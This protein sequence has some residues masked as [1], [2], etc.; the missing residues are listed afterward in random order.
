VLQADN[1]NWR[2]ICALEFFNAQRSTLKKIVILAASPSILILK[3]LNQGRTAR[4]SPWFC[5]FKGKLE[6]SEWNVL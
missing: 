3:K 2:D 5:T 4:V 6:L 1:A